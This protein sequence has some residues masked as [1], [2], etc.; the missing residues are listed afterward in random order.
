M[1]YDDFNTDKKLLI[2]FITNQCKRLGCNTSLNEFI[3]ND[4]TYKFTPKENLENFGIYHSKNSMKSKTLPPLLFHE[5]NNKFKKELNFPYLSKGILFHKSAPMSHKK[6]Y[7]AFLPDNVVGLVFN[8]NDIKKH[9]SHLLKRLTTQLNKKS[10]M[11]S[12][13]IG[14]VIAKVNVLSNS[15][16]VSVFKNFSEAY[17]SIVEKF[18]NDHQ[19]IAKHYMKPLKAYMDN[20][21]SNCPNGSLELFEQYDE[22]IVNCDSVIYLN[23]KDVESIMDLDE[24]KQSLKRQQYNYV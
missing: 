3:N 23:I 9:N 21:V 5:L 19:L 17:S 1:L 14:E 13:E 2:D 4:T 16:L 7:I 15:S 8:S 22:M 20:Y 12:F 18:P 10:D 11:D 24:L 6:E